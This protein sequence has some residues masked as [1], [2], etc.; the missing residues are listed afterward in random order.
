MGLVR[1]TNELLRSSRERVQCLVADASAQA[2][3]VMAAR[4][5]A[6]GEE[7]ATDFKTYLKE[8]EWPDRL[9]S[10]IRSVNCAYQMFSADLYDKLVQLGGLTRAAAL[11]L[12]ERFLES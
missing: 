5:K 9:Q 12:T 2:S 10:Q 3:R 11:A 6:A 8:N 4:C 1:T 7:L